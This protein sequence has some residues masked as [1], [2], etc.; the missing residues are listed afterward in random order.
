[1]MYQ[2][3]NQ[4]IEL[5]SGQVLLIVLNL[6]HHLVLYLML[7]QVLYQVLLLFSSH[8][9]QRVKRKRVTKASK[10]KAKRKAPNPQVL[11]LVSSHLLQ[12]VK[13]KRVTK[14]SQNKARRKPRKATNQQQKVQK[15][16]SLYVSDQ[17]E[18]KKNAIIIK[19]HSYYIFDLIEVRRYILFFVC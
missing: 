8:L 16:K 7:C 15:S 12:R 11:L 14:T 6:V 10:S 2:V 4:V 19:H 9:L 17:Y 3:R 5:V 13:G 1:V 18:C